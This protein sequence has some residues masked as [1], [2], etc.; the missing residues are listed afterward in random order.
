MLHIFVPCQE[1]QIPKSPIDFKSTVSEQNESRKSQDLEYQ[2]MYI[3]QFY[4][5]RLLLAIFALLAQ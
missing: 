4:C 2:Y 1:Q 5:S 3:D